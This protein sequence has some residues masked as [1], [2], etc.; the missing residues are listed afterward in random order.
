[1]ASSDA[2][3]FCAHC[4][5]W[6]RERLRCPACGCRLSVKVMPKAMPQLRPG[7]YAMWDDDPI[8]TARGARKAL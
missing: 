8:A 2:P 4:K 7:V 1:M 3:D 5:T 6:W